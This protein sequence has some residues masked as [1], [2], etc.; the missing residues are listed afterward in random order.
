MGRGGNQSNGK[1]RRTPIPHHSILKGAGRERSTLK[2]QLNQ[3]VC[4]TSEQDLS[5]ILSC[6]ANH[7]SYCSSSFLPSPS[8]GGRREVLEENTTP[9]ATTS[10]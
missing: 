2:I 7:V 4:E 6:S 5:Q 1:E 8:K 10:Q 3:D 9:R